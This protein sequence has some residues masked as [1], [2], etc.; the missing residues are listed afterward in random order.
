MKAQLSWMKNMEFSCDNQGM[1]TLID[2]APDHG[3]H[4]VGP[5]PK[6]LI[7]NA[8]MGCTA[9]DV[10]SILHKM[11]Q[12]ITAFNME[13]EAVKTTQYPT[14]FSSAELVYLLTGPIEPEKAIKAVESSL[15][16]YCGV[17]YMMSKTCKL[18]YRIN[19]NNQDIKT[20][21]VHFIEPKPEE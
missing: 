10:V 4:Q 19:L 3:G 17:N 1:K 16:K 18:T 14:H 8:M 20:G 13:V 7:L 12:E 15:T 2:A 11:R 9:M 6:E 5:T 21:S